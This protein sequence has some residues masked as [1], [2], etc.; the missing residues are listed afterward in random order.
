MGVPLGPGVL[1]PAQTTRRK[2][3]DLEA[4]NPGFER[5]THPSLQGN[6]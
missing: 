2:T 4:G 6:A 3:A 5:D 1:L